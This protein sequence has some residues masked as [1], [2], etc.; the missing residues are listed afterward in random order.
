VATK[1]PTNIVSNL[2]K[3]TSGRKHS[4]T[5]VYPAS[6]HERILAKKTP[7]QYVELYDTTLRDG[8]QGVG[9]NFT[10]E[11]KLKIA[12]HLS[13]FGVKIIEGGWPSEV[14]PS[15]AE[16]FKRFSHEGLDATISAIG[17]TRKPNSRPPRDQNLKDIL[18]VEADYVT[19]V[20]KSWRLHVE[21]VLDT[22]LEENLRMITDS[23]EYLS[24]HGRE[25]IFD[26]E[27]FFDGFK[28]DPE[29]ATQTVMAAIDGG[30][31]TAVLCDTRGSSIPDEVREI[32]LQI[33]KKISKTIGI[34]AHND[35][36]LA[37][38]ISLSAVM[39][40]ARHFQGT[41][42]GIGERCGNAN[43]I[44]FIA[45]LEFSLGYKTGHDLT[46]LTQL[47]DYVN[48][49]ANL[50]RNSYMP[51]VGRYAFAHK[52]GLHG[53][54]VMRL[55]KAY[56]SIDPSL[57]GNTRMITVSSQ[58]GL[59]NII[60]KA[61][62]FGFKLDK[63]NPKARTIL[64]K[65]KEMEAVG[66]NLENANGTLNLL[67]AQDFGVNLDFFDL[68]NWRAFVT[69]EDGNVRAES[70]VKMIVDGE[71]I[72][73]A[74]EGNGPVNAFD[75]ALRK[76]LRVY[77]PELKEVKLTGYRVREINVEKGTAAAVRVFTE[78]EAK[79]M[80]WSTVGVSTNVLK[81]SEE[82]LIDGYIYFLFKSENERPKSGEKKN[83]SHE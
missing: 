47:S 67:Y 45:N 53:H 77:Y 52:A 11:D 82:A 16:F 54:A 8:N 20:G 32:T 25:V 80:R 13:N 64:L 56:E 12:R 83:R 30:A 17:A 69:G 72:I 40:G 73:T 18:S 34:H 9:I 62:E 4:E 41:V 5:D 65:I 38:A 28:A 78:F 42:N 26:A 68:V 71:T 51:F 61:Q 22:T 39:A 79:G 48:E 59:A 27:H 46:K 49:I 2:Q 31:K 35:R 63:E 76:A 15:E 44:E 21:K 23:I 58:A 24:E 81:A 29:Y 57:V 37:T 55:A 75:M 50:D 14:N 1:F 43:L 36:G 7:M 6:I 60:S 74:G 33:S 10:V 19:I 70:T 66:Y 3:K